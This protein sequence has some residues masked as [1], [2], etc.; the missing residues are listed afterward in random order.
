MR[1]KTYLHPHTEQ[2]E[3]TQTRPL[4]YY[5]DQG[6]LI[7]TDTYVLE[8]AL[9]HK[10][11]RATSKQPKQWL[12]KYKGYPEPE[13]QPAS[14]FLHDINDDW[15]AYNTKHGIS[16]DLRDVRMVHSPHPQP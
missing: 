1:I 4:H 8:K 16:V 3:G 11:K 15:L 9:D 6:F 10:P 7:E 12:V 14:S 13:W 2:G 5:T